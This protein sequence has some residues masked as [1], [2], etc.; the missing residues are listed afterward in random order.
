MAAPVLF[1]EAEYADPP[2]T[3]LE[4]READGT[5]LGCT[6]YTHATR[7]AVVLWYGGETYEGLSG[8]YRWGA[9]GAPPSGAGSGG[10]PDLLD[11]DS[12]VVPTRWARKRGGGQHGATGPDP[13]AA[14]AGPQL[15]RCF[16]PFEQALAVARSIGQA[17]MSGEKEW[18][19]WCKN[20]MRPAGI[21]A[22]PHRTYKD[23]GWQGWGHWLGTG[24]TSTRAMKFLP[25]EEALP[26]GARHGQ[27]LLKRQALHCA[28]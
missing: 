23:A 19:A 7:G 27:R 1:V 9:G 26:A 14:A 6:A 8:D 18:R 20:G 13:A 25:F 12:D 17:G 15:T 22:N 5:W 24:T 3:G 16:L 21:P 2:C 11:G 28:G 10:A 4:T